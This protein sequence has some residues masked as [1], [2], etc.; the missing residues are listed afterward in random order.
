MTAVAKASAERAA[1]LHRIFD[2][3]A[4]SLFMVLRNDEQLPAAL[5][6]TDLDVCVCPDTSPEE[7]LAYLVAAGKE[8]GWSA[9]TVSRRPHM[10]GFSLVRQACEQ[11]DAVHFDVF[12]GITYLG[13]P[14]CGPATLFAESSVDNGVRRLSPRA[15]ALATVAHHLAWNGYLSK[16]KYRTEF[17]EISRMPTDRA[18]LRSC[19]IDMFGAPTADALLSPSGLSRLARPTLSGRISIAAA[20]TRRSAAKGIA[21]SSRQVVGYWRAQFSSLRSPPGLVGRVGDALPDVPELRLTSELACAISPHGC[22]APSVR[23]RS[24]RVRTLNGPRYQGTTSRTWAR[25]AL[26]R[27]TMPSLFLLYQVKRNRVIVLSS[28]LPLGLRVLR[29]RAKRQWI[30]IPT[31]AGS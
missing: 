28:R 24:S 30:G 4:E 8:L 22:T 1:L 10:I 17:T 14:L 25:W 21:L 5:S 3:P 9:V 29:H 6:G 7:T 18:W 13:L 15:K 2:G 19:L 31:A 12:N 20:L 27:W 11:A 26:L 23:C 16:E